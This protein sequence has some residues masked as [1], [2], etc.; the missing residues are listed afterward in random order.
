MLNSS[1]RMLQ[2][3]VIKVHPTPLKSPFVFKTCNVFEQSNIS[4][5]LSQSCRKKRD[6]F[7]CEA[8]FHYFECETD[9][10]VKKKERFKKKKIRIRKPQCHENVTRL[11]CEVGLKH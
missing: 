7:F 2:L 11:G 4:L 1:L 8:V 10:N 5:V 6:I 9:K 3:M